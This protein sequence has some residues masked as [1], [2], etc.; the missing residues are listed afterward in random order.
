ME[1]KKTIGI[2]REIK[3][4]W[5]RRCALTPKEVK[6]LVAEDIRILVQ[7]STSRC[8][9]DEEFLEAGAIL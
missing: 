9:T 7:P 8:Y 6:V 1:S 2:L 3:S 4:K 5:E